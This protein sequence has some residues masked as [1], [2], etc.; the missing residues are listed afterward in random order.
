MKLVIWELPKLMELVKPPPIPAKMPAPRGSADVPARTAGV[1]G[2]LPLIEREPCGIDQDL[3]GRIARGDAQALASFY[4]RH[5]GV[6]FSVAA[7]ILGDASAAEDV[8]QEVFLLLWEKARSYDPRLG[9]PL[10][11]V[12]TFTRNKC[13]DRLRAQ[14]RQQ[15]LLKEVMESGPQISAEPQRAVN[16]IYQYELT[17]AVAMA[18]Q[19]LPKEQRLAIEMAFFRGMT[20][21][22]IAAALEA[23]L[24]TVKAR[25]RRGMLHLRT[26]LSPFLTSSNL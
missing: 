3:L 1:W 19:G 18:L 23:P 4:D 26:K 6:L 2:E 16:Q 8:L 21:S 20:Q 10:S 13:V 25:I 24:G 14:Q 9:R 15:K 12:M 5:I 7:R 17:Q 22:E 11:W